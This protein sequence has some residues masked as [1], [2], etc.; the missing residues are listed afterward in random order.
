MS[1]KMTEQRLNLE[2]PV[3][4]WH[5]GKWLLAPWIISHFPPHRTYV[6]PFGGAASVLIRK[7]RSYA[8]VYND[9][10]RTAVDV[11]RCMRDP[12]LAAEL[13]QRL[14]LTPFAR[15]EFKGAYSTETDDLVERA[16]K[17][18]VR[19]FMGFGSASTNGEHI[20]GF[21]A[22]SRRSGATHNWQHYPDCIPSFVARLR[23]VVIENKDAF[24]VIARHDAADTLIYA[25][26]PYPHETR[27]M[28]RGNASYAHEFETADHERLGELLRSC[29]SMVVVSSYPSRLYDRL[30]AGW[31][32]VECDAFADG[33]RRRREVLYLNDSCATMQRQQRLIA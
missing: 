12:A 27:N 11:F 15:D 25:D 16:R 29:K 22:S 4:R 26:P 33:A 28:R 1:N 30:Y 14:R 32:V 20:T 24:E 18:I 13:D 6:E 17:A 7:P 21:R 3:M 31:A 8:E 2:R 5:G 9:T 10:W 19:S 23:G